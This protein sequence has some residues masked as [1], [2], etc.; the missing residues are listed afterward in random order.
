MPLSRRQPARRIPRG[1]A[2]RREILSEAARILLRDGLD[3][4]SMDSIATEA[5]A[6]KATIYR[7]FGDRA[8]LVVAV[9]QHLCEEFIADV[10]RKPPA[11]S[12][13][14]TG[15]R[16]I[17]SELVRVLRKPRHPEFFGLIVAGTR[18][19]AP[20]IGRAWYDHGPRVWHRLL[21][22]VFEI[23][24]DRGAL[25]RDADVSG[26]PELLFDAVFADII[27]QTA[28]LGMSDP[29]RSAAEHDLDRL[30]DAVIGQ[31]ERTGR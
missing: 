5:G 6:S 18:A 20:E 13:L 24:R 19:V 8:G 28:I 11:G 12:D 3:A 29:P 21:H 15:L 7:H 9:V 1:Q 23:Q 4:T 25:P 27:I 22:D 14:R 17:L 30:V 31:L 16:A 26:Y 10:D 2:R